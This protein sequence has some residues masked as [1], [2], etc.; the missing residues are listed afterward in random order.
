VRRPTKLWVFCNGQE[1]NIRKMLLDL[2]I[3][4]NGSIETCFNL[5][6]NTRIHRNALHCKIAAKAAVKAYALKME[7]F[8]NIELDA[9]SE[10]MD[11]KVL[12]VS[13]MNMKTHFGEEF[14]NVDLVEAKDLN[15]YVA[16]LNK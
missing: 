11:H 5:M 13:T 6:N 10:T 9:E 4:E 15:E 14:G 16:S 7:R 3:P 1:A 2:D 12:I 8:M